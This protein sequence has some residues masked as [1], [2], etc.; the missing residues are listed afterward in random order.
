M[1]AAVVD[2]STGT[3]FPYRLSASGWRCIHI[4]GRGLSKIDERAGSPPREL[5][6]SRCRI[7]YSWW[8]MRSSEG[9]GAKLIGRREKEEV[10]KKNQVSRPHRRRWI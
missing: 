4:A 6:V 5:D 3:W 1:G 9:G 7:S 10:E 8:Y 2:R